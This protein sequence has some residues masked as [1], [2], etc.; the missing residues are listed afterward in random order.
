MAGEENPCDENGCN[1][2]IFCVIFML[3]LSEVLTS[4]AIPHFLPESITI[5][6]LAITLNSLFMIVSI[7]GIV[8]R[9]SVLFIPYIVIKVVFIIGLTIILSRFIY[10]K[11]RDLFSFTGFYII[12][13]FL[14]L[15]FLNEFPIIV[16]RSY[17]E[18]WKKQTEGNRDVEISNV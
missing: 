9:K 11:T 18:K 16:M 3:L 6:V 5:S 7:I 1:G 10:T 13:L 2:P 12:A 4:F 17:Y 15:I 8:F 14:V